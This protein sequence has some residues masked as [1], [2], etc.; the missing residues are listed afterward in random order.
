MKQGVE[1]VIV[2]ILFAS[3]CV[4][5]GKKSACFFSG[6]LRGES[7]AAKNAK[8]RKKEEGQ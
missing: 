7:I 2:L 4:L 3:L 6:G 5:C 8:R 1:I